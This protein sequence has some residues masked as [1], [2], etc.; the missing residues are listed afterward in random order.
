M[1]AMESVSHTYA[2][3]GLYLSR[4]APLTLLPAGFLILL[5]RRVPVLFDCN[6]RVQFAVV[7]IHCEE[8]SAR[9]RAS[10]FHCRFH[11]HYDP[12]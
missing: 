4:P 5:E 8:K 3:L 1:H 7:E 11:G 9:M 12:C 10:L 6:T 2:F